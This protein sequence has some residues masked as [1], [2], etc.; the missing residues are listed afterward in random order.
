MIFKCPRQKRCLCNDIYKRQGFVKTLF[1]NKLH[2]C[3]SAFPRNT[4]SSQSSGVVVWIIQVTAKVAWNRHKNP[5]LR[6][7][8]RQAL[9]T[10]GMVDVFFYS[11][12]PSQHCIQKH[13]KTPDITSSIVSLF[14][15]DLRGHKIGSVTRCHQ[16]TICR[17][18]LFS[19]PKVNNSQRVW[20]SAVVCVHDIAGF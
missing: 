15:Q 18:Y 9:S 16:K 19:E 3:Q 4:W 11:N 20:A 5:N 6:N 8:W 7:N 12:S 2:K 10:K 1:S 17:S 13:A 14:L